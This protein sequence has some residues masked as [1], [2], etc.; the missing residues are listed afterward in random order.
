MLTGIL[1]L[2]ITDIRSFSGS[3]VLFC[4]LLYPV[5]VILF[6]LFGYPP[7]S[8]LTA[9]GDLNSFS[10]YYSVTAITLIASIPVGYG[11]LFAFIHQKQSHLKGQKRTGAAGNIY[12]QMLI[13]ASLSF[14]VVLPLIYLSDPVSTEG[15]LRSIYA[16]ILLAVMASFI[17]LFT[18]CI[19]RNRENLKIP[20]FVSVILLITVPAGLLLHH[21]WNYFIF[22]SPFYWFSWSWVIA[23]P[24]ESSLYG[25]ISLAITAAGML[26]LCRYIARKPDTDS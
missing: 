12:I 3:P 18:I 26:I 11:L 25:I 16:A 9:S 8:G 4:V 15:W 20:F 17:Y 10:A 24:A 19:S 6:L 21:P 14:L 23:S 13:P 5:F 1:K 2:I 22:F 7:L